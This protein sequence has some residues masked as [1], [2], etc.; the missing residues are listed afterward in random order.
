ME[1]CVVEVKCGKD[2]FIQFAVYRPYAG[3]IDDF[4]IQIGRLLQSSVLRGKS[5]ILLGDINIDLLRTTCI[6]VLEFKNTMQSLSFLPVITKATR[7]PPGN[8]AGSPSLLD[9]IWVNTIRT[10]STGILNIDITD[11][12]LTFI[13]FPIVSK[14][15]KIK[16]SFCVHD[17]SSMMKFRQQVTELSRL[18][19]F[20]N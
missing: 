18:L 2:A 14:V 1:T 10:F 3:P 17:Q 16:L 13:N 19:N 20:T 6:G 12:C 8:A 9:H 5:V 11:H 7:F 15:H 4:S